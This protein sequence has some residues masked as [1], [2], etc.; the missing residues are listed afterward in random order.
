LV[1]GLNNGARLGDVS[2]S[3]LAGEG[4]GGGE[5]S[6]TAKASPP[7]P[8]LPP[9][10]GREQ[11]GTAP[12]DRGIAGVLQLSPLVWA[13]SWADLQRQRFESRERFVEGLMLKR[14][15]SIYRVGRVRGDWWKWK[16]A[17]YTIDAVLIYA[18]PGHGKRASLFT[19]Y[20]FGVW[21]DGDLV[22]VTKAYSGLT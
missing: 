20:T 1:N 3:P 15:N 14:L 13:D 4:R 19:D 12:A 7:Q 18:Q 22:P 8:N 2:P 11:N 9:P 10:G 21:D 5:S 16:V 17:P 6:P